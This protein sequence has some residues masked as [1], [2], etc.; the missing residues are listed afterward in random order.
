MSLINT[1]KQEIRSKLDHTVD[2]NEH[3]YTK[4]GFL[5]A[6]REMTASPNSILSADIKAKALASEGR[7]MKIPVTSPGAVTITNVRSCII[8]DMENESAFIEVIFTTY[9]ANITMLK[10]QYAINEIAYLEDLNKKLMAVDHKFAL[11]VETAIHTSMEAEKSVVYP[12]STFVG[13]GLKYPLVGDAMQVAAADQEHFYNDVPVIMEEDDYYN[14]LKVLASTSHKAPVKK[15]VAQGASNDENLNYQ[16]G[17]IDY[18]FSNRGLNGAAVKS[19]GFIVP[20]GEITQLFRNGID[21]T[22]KSKSSDGT[23]WD[24]TFMEKLGE[25]VGVMYKSTCDDLSAKQAGIDH[26]KASLYEQFQFSFDHA[27][28]KAYHKNAPVNGTAVR[29]FE[30]L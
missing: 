9:V 13:V 18:R 21:F 14:D 28:V 30:F 22:T 6:V 11:T 2:R 29:K 24:L 7:A 23:E 26:L 16:F 17:G 25:Q 10:N 19:T 12:N 3:R 5:E 1:Y 27:I 8:P 20:D 4:Y 15:F